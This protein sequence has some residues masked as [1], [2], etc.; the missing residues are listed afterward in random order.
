[1]RRGDVQRCSAPVD[2]G[3]LRDLTDASGGRTAI[4]RDPRELNAATKSVADE[5][6]KQ[7]YLGYPASEKKDGRW[8]A[9]RVEVRDH[10]YRV[11]AR[12]GYV[13]S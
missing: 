8:H 12:E 9:I 6:S 5:L 11:R 2:A 4:I 13:A 10:H 3:A 7:Y 1:M